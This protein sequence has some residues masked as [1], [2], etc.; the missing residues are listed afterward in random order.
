MASCFRGGSGISSISSLPSLPHRTRLSVLPVKCLSSRQSRDSDS[1]SDLRTTPSPSSTSGFSPYGWCAG[2]GGVGFLETT[3]LS[4]LRLTNSDAFCPI[5]GASCGDVLNSDYAVVFGVPLPFIGMF[6]Y[7]LFF[8]SLKEFSV[9][10]IQ[11]VLGV[12]LCIASLVVAALSTSYSSIE[13][14][15]SSLAEANLPFFETEITTSSSPFALSLAK[16]LHAIG[17]KM[18]GAFWC[19]HCLEQKQMF[20]SKA[21]KQLNYVECFPDGYRKGTKIAK[22][23]SDAKIEGFPT[24]VINGQVLSGEQDLSD[25]AKASG[26]PEMSQPS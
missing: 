3:Y 21:V 15:S 2:I 24:W 7:G 9:E 14:L 20:G 26:F 22:A 1:D 6:A 25:L 10:E 8:I 18:Y 17:A 12:Q 5:G 16:H 13:P 11:K 23:C 4:Y 19:S